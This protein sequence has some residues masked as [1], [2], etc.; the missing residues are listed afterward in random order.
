MQSNVNLRKQEVFGHAAHE[1][2]TT[3]MIEHSFS[4]LFSHKPFGLYFSKKASC[5]AFI[6]PLLL[7]QT[8]N[9]SV[10]P[11]AKLPTT[12]EHPTPLL[13]DI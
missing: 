9:T 6:A 3:Y 5:L 13:L 2:D 11:E 10:T 12:Q 1:N 4:F 8:H 7:L